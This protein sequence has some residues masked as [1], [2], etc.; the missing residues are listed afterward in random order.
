M[1]IQSITLDALIR[2]VNLLGTIVSFLQLILIVMLP[3][4]SPDGDEIRIRIGSNGEIPQDQDQRQSMIQLHT[5]TGLLS[6]DDSTTKPAPI[7]D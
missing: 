7:K 2:V 6:T 4:E 5:Q 1:T 3:R